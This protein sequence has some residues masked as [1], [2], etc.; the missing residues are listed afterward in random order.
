MRPRQWVKN[1]LVLAAPVAAGSLFQVPV[2]ISTAWAFLAFCLIS[3]SIYLINDVRDV[4][5]DRQHPKKRLRPIAAGELSP[6][7]ALV[8]A[9]VCLV[10]A[11]ALGWFVAPLLALT[12]A[13]YWVL[14][15]GYSLFLKNEPIIDLAM[16]ASGFLLR[17]VAGG[18][19]SGIELSQWFLLVAAFGSL[20]MVAGKRYSEIS[21]LGAEAWTRASLARYTATYLRFVWTLAC[22]A[23]ILCYSL[24]A[25][26]QH[27]DLEWLG[28]P[29][30]ALSIAPFTLALLRYAYVIDRGDA[31]EPED[32]VLTDRVLQVLAVLWVVPL[33]IGVFS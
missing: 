6:R 4:E 30:A 26:E 10:A 8:L 2:L 29:W 3:A 18:V 5:A 22:T 20:F 13:V 15:V 11:V 19:A 24:W 1:V 7:T 32:V 23:V 16:V 21:E 17:A 9:A 25:F 12:V 27:G 33:G 28:L 31:G 14:Q